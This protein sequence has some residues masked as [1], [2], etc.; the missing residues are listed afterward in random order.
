M[1]RIRSL[2]LAVL[3][4][5]AQDIPDYLMIRFYSGDAGTLKWLPSGRYRL[6]ARLL[7]NPSDPVFFAGLS[8]EI[9]KP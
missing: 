8:F 4:L 9:R 3:P 5:V 2:L 7:D 1:W 6:T